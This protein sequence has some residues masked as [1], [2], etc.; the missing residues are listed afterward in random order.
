[1]LSSSGM[2]IIPAL[3]GN[4]GAVC[5]SSTLRPDHPR[6]RGEYAEPTRCRSPWYGSS[7]LS[8]GILVVAVPRESDGVD[9]PRS[10]GEYGS[11]AGTSFKTMRIIPA[12]AGN[13]NHETMNPTASW[14]H[15]RSRGEYFDLVD[16]RGEELG[17]SPLS[18]GIPA[19]RHTTPQR[20]RII[21]ALAGN[22]PW[23][24]TPSPPCRDHPRSRG[25]YY[26]PAT[27]T[28]HLDGSSPLSRGIQEP[29]FPPELLLGSSPLSRGIPARTH[30]ALG[31]LRI[32]P[33][34]AGNTPIR[35]IRIV[36][37]WDHPRS[38][39][40]YRV[41]GFWLRALIGSSPLS[42]GILDPKTMGPETP[43]IIP[44]LAGNT[45][46][47][48]D[49]FTHVRDH[50]RSRGEYKRFSRFRAQ[51]Q[52]SSPLSRGIRLLAGQGGP[53][54]RII[55]ALAGNTPSGH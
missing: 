4:T 6:S 45:C 15:P 2:G 26:S 53:R 52:G 54:S 43:G 35:G 48:V 38:R 13:T 3:A 42:R 8:R 19:T 24:G 18:R 17:S 44:A 7:P 10:R 37:A 5:G 34:L 12:L 30:E 22:T 46:R 33:A 27:R 9:H 21:P 49:P 32:I 36:S 1:M 14:D 16:E 41:F 29:A 28:I 11:D 39:G 40:E 47:P 23:N 25:E 50:P 20:P 51:N 31:R 55:P